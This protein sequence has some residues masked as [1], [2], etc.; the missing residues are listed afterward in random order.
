MS[1]ARKQNADGDKKRRHGHSEQDAIDNSD[2]TFPIDLVNTG[3]QRRRSRGRR[4]FTVLDRFGAA[5]CVQFYLGN[6]VLAERC[7]GDASRRFGRLQ[8]ETFTEKF[9]SM[10]ESE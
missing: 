2:N 10:G 6:R 9:I 5:I 8:Q 1:S 7:N 4:P 3:L